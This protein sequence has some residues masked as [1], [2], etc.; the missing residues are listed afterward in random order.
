M[1]Q[2]LYTCVLGQLCKIYGQMIRRAE[3]RIRVN[4]VKIL[5]DVVAVEELDVLKKIYDVK[6]LSRFDLGGEGA[7]EL[8]LKLLRQC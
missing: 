3:P 8:A 5:L 4:L 7:V 1:V 6:A 2:C